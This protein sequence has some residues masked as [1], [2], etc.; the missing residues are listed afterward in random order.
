[1]NKHPADGARRA[2]WRERTGRDLTVL[3]SSRC[4]HWWEYRLQ[5]SLADGAVASRVCVLCGK[6]ESLTFEEWEAHLGRVVADQRLRG[7]P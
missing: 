6:S 7:G 4:A 5:V 1:M 2:L 3:Q